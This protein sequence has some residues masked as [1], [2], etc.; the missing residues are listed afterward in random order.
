MPPTTRSLTEKA[1]IADRRDIVSW[2]STL[3][4]EKVFYERFHEYDE[5]GEVLFV[6]LRVNDQGELVP[7]ANDEEDGTEKIYLESMTR[8]LM[9]V[10]DQDFEMADDDSVEEGEVDPDFVPEAY[11]TADEDHVDVQRLAQEAQMTPK[12]RRAPIK[13]HRTTKVDNT[14]PFPGNSLPV[15]TLSALL[16][17]G[18]IDDMTDLVQHE[19]ILD[20]VV[21]PLSVAILQSTSQKSLSSMLTNFRVNDLSEVNGAGAH[22]IEKEAYDSVRPSKIINGR[23]VLDPRPIVFRPTNPAYKEIVDMGPL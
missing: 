15:A 12:Q 19:S 16:A 6:Q 20:F 3:T 1:T 7:W 17:V 5:E 11:R 10:E 18:M 4:G 2:T 14:T 8:R 21:G 9:T 13:R 23:R 22:A